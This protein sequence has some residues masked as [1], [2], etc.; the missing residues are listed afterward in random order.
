MEVDR[1]QSKIPVRRRFGPVLH[2]TVGGVVAGFAYASATS[3][4]FEDAADYF[5]P[6]AVHYCA[7]GAL[8]G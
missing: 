2:C 5:F 1:P 4:L 7:L 8:G 3:W 6:A